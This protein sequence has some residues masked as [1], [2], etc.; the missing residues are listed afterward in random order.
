MDQEDVISS[1]EFANRGQQG[2]WDDLAMD[3]EME[4]VEMEEIEML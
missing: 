1:L 3:A 2:A 4:D